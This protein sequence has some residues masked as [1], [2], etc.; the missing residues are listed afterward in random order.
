MNIMYHVVVTSGNVVTID[1]KIQI[2]RAFDGAL[3]ILRTYSVLV[4][5][6]SSDS[7]R[8]CQAERLL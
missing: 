4:I 6:D 1:Y 2:Q 3:P 8:R 5:R 7:A